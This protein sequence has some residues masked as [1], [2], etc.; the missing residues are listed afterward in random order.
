M[1]QSPNNTKWSLALFSTFIDLCLVDTQGWIMPSVPSARVSCH[2]C[3][4]PKAIRKETTCLRDSSPDTEQ[5]ESEK[6][7]KR[8]VTII[9]AG[10]GGLSAANSLAN[11]DDTKSL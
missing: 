8:R 3:V 2:G 6:K 4:A 7:S 9:G 1:M 5:D 10:W 11:K